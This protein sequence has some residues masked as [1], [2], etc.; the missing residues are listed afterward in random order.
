MTSGSGA[1]PGKHPRIQ[2]RFRTLLPSS[3]GL[4]VSQKLRISQIPHLEDHPDIL[5]VAKDLEPAPNAL[6]SIFRLRKKA[7]VPDA[8]E[9]DEIIL[10]NDVPKLLPLVPIAVTNLAKKEILARNNAGFVSNKN[11]KLI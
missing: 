5:E 7:K 2:L 1:R 6:I 9:F 8:K 4:R 3:A 11:L 10:S